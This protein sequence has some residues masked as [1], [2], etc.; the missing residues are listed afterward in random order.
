MTNRHMNV[1]VV[2]F[3]EQ[4]GQELVWSDPDDGIPDPHDA[5][6]DAIRVPGVCR[7]IELPQVG[8]R[9]PVTPA[10]Y[11]YDVYWEPATGEVHL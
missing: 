10:R 5:P 3:V 4:W 6:D 1:D 9:G 11:T 8:P 7:V 2:T